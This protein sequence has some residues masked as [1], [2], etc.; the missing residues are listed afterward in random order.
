MYFTNISFPITLTLITFYLFLIF[1]LFSKFLLTDIC[2]PFTFYFDLLLLFI[3][4][5]FLFFTYVL[6]LVFTRTSNPPPL[7]PYVSEALLCLG[8]G[9]NI[10]N[11]L[12]CARISRH[13]PRLFILF[14]F[15]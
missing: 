11:F 2:L 10:Y 5:F 9:T 3:L 13:V 8:R 4:L 1:N 12:G 7:P 6:F 15:S 14:N